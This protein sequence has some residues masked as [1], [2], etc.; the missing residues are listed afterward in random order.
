MLG[1]WD[2]SPGC[3]LVYFAIQPQKEQKGGWWGSPFFARLLFSW[4]S[5]CV[6]INTGFHRAWITLLHTIHYL[7]CFVYLDL[8]LGSKFLIKHIFFP[9]KNSLEQ[10]ILERRSI[11]QGCPFSAV[12]VTPYLA[13][14]PRCS[15]LK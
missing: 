6:G 7:L 9:Q 2:V 14:W 4:G 15:I 13:Y 8:R 10:T 12:D 1:P 11:W 5:R 3:S